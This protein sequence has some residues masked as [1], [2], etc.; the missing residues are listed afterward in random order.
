[1][2]VKYITS[3]NISIYVY[4]YIYEMNKILHNKVNEVKHL[5]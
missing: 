1:M 5:P 2:T 4:I 3:N